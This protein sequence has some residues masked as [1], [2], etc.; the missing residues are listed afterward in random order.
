MRVCKKCLCTVEMFKDAPV[1]S[2]NDGTM[3]PGVNV[4][5]EGVVGPC[6]QG[7]LTRTGPDS[8]IRE[9]LTAAQLSEGQISKVCFASAD[10]QHLTTS[11]GVSSVCSEW[12][13]TIMDV[14]MVHV[15][16]VSGI[17]KR[18][19]QRFEGEVASDSDLARS[20]RKEKRDILEACM[21]AAIASK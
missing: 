15:Q 13:Q 11:V 17:C 16:V 12:H 7:I 2:L 5:F 1:P 19:L 3:H 18:E 20:F 6:M 21:R 9:L 4:P 14:S 8:K 10:S